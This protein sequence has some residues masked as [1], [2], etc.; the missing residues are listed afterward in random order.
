MDTINFSRSACLKDFVDNIDNI[1]N[2][3]NIN[4]I[5]INQKNIMI[6]KNQKEFGHKKRIKP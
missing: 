6:I 3:N 4:N 2:I 5:K 1:N